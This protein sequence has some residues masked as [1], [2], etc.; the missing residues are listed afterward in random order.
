VSWAW[1][2]L[3]VFDDRGR[4]VRT[5]V[6]GPAPA[7]EAVAVWNGRDDHG[8]AVRPGVFS[9]RL[10]IGNDYHRTLKTTMLLAGAAP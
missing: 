8:R 2:C 3:Q 10:R 6:D 4:L 5:L 7:E 9:C 1:P